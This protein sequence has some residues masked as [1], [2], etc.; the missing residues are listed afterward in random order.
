MQQNE[1]RVDR[2][3]LAY[4]LC[5]LAFSPAAP[6]LARENDNAI[7]PSPSHPARILAPAVTLTVTNTNNSGA[8]SLRAALAT[9]PTGNV[10]QFSLPV[11]SVISVTGGELLAFYQ[12]TIDGST[13]TNLIIDANNAS[14]AINAL[15][16]ITI[17][18]L[19]IQNANAGS[20]GGAG[21]NAQGSLVLTNVSVFSSTAGY[22]GGGVFAQG[23]ATVSG[24]VFRNNRS[25]DEAGGGGGM[26]AISTLE[27]TGTQFISNTAYDQGGGLLAYQN[28]VL[29]NVVFM[30]NSVANASGSGDGGGG[31]LLYGGT[32]AVVNGGMFQ[33]N[34]SNVFGG[35]LYALVRLALSGTQ[36]VNNSAGVA[37]GGV[38]ASQPSTLIGAQFLRNSAVDD[39]GGLA[40]G[41]IELLSVGFSQNTA[42]NGGG[43]SS[44]GTAT[45]TNSVFISNTAL[46]RGGGADL[47][48]VGISSAVSGG[49]F[50]HNTASNGGGVYVAAAITV[51]GTQ[52]VSNT[53]GSRGGGVYLGGP[54]S[55]NSAQF[56]SNSAASHGGGVFAAQ[57][58]TVTDSLFRFNRSV[59]NRGGGA[60]AGSGLILERSRFV[61]NEAATGGG[62]YFADLLLAARNSLFA[63]NLATSG[64]GAGLYYSSTY[65]SSIQHST[66]ASPTLAVGSAI[67]GAAGAL[68]VAN[69]LIASHT[70][71]IRRAGLSI[72]V[73][74]SDNFFAGNTANL[75]GT[76]GSAGQ[77][78]TGNPA[79]VSPAG[80]N[81]HLGA[82]SA[83]INA[84]PF[85]GV[86]SDIDL[87]P[88]VVGC[89]DAGYDEVIK[90]A[91]LCKPAPI[92]NSPTFLG[93]PTTFTATVTGTL[94]VTL[95]W[96]FG[97]GT[98]TATGGVV[99]HT[100]G[101]MGTYTAVVTATNA[102][103]SRAAATLVLVCGT[104][105]SNTNDSGAGS[106]RTAVQ[107]ANAGG[108]ITF[109]P[110]LAGKTI[111]LTSGEI[112][113][114][115]TLTLNGGGAPGVR[116]SAN[117]AS[118]MFNAFSPTTFL[119]LTIQHGAAAGNGGGILS[120][121]A[122]TLTNV[123]VLINTA[124]GSGGGLYTNGDL[125]LANVT[126]VSNTSSGG[127]GGL[128]GDGARNALNGVV[129]RENRCTGADCRGGA[130][131]FL[132]GATLV[133]VQVLTN[134][135]TGGG[136]GVY[137]IGAAMITG[138]VFLNN[139]CTTGACVGGGL[140]QPI[141]L[142]LSISGTQF[143]SNSAGAGGGGAYGGGMVTL[144]GSLF[145][146]NRTSSGFGG[147]LDASGALIMTATQF[148]SNT[149]GAGG[150]A[151][152]SGAAVLEGGVFQGNAA[153]ISGGGFYGI[154]TL[155]MSGTQFIGNQA[156][157]DAGGARAGAAGT[158]RGSLFR[159]NTGTTW[160]GG[161]LATELTLIDTTFLSNTSGYGG[162]AMS[163]LVVPSEVTGGL[164]QGNVA[165]SNDGGGL[166]VN[167]A[168]TIS[169]TQF[170]GNL[171]AGKGGHVNAGL[172]A[173][174][175]TNARFERGVATN[176]GGLY[177]GAGA[178]T[179]TDT[180]VLGNVATGT[181]GAGGVHVVNTATVVGGLFQD[182]RTNGVGGGL[183]A[184]KGVALTGTQFISNSSASNGGGLSLLSGVGRVV[185][186][187]F[188]RNTSPA[189]GG[190]MEFGSPTTVTIV[191]V[192]VVGPQDGVGMGIVTG[193][194][195]AGITNTVIASYTYGIF[196]HTSA[197][198]ENY[199]L[200]H[201]N[202]TE[203]GGA[204][205]SGGNSLIGD[206]RFTN[207]AVDDYHLT[208]GSAARNAG[209][210]AGI[211]VDFEGDARPIGASFDIGYDE[212]R[213]RLF[214]PNTIRN[215]S[216]GW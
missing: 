183:F 207:A 141:G 56:V 149:A 187:L 31:A 153:G 3:I 53:T 110:L 112:V 50:R 52:F 77:T 111:T 71:G 60:Y 174:S 17:A 11:N 83:A 197:V 102:F 1:F 8:G 49:L 163:M 103:G 180:R 12:V 127:G 133:N 195:T 192:T 214:V 176:G 46:G 148:I 101:A 7:A 75:S 196:N 171:A 138:G 208:G 88:R 134:T 118:R 131:R 177:V 96:N 113:I 146:R 147:G 23:P 64:L 14:R 55:L 106:L 40:A 114:S 26:Y 170:I 194:G 159:D 54:A 65:L 68:N 216:S 69:S 126:M 156:A 97:D 24:G 82:G 32:L 178:L 145:Q 201:A 144:A 70:V 160:G 215:R 151:S 67:E 164:F 36:F 81:Y 66:F 27:M 193:M 80:D 172:R 62:V 78:S 9:A 30:S 95:T 212:W 204:V 61:A 124:T 165:R 158:A 105:V 19:T 191:H 100:Y 140:W 18:S 136:G 37:G 43:L 57:P 139:A 135:S 108:T 13:A 152:T 143:I 22:R 51:T 72:F 63:R 34:A 119:S 6:A 21:I 93:N 10:I 129:L 137:V 41:T 25:T 199:N 44:V 42:G 79:F 198:F 200:F 92:N 182:N 185:N 38:F 4:C 125:A 5:S 205:T 94:P 87:H 169:G 206:P 47:F 91:S 33:S 115:K 123:N 213:G 86:S 28:V 15:Q 175:V 104:L 167:G 20:L 85:I 186:S 2:L 59:G 39:G 117:G 188:A 90:A 184:G 210:N 48:G 190:A 157:G 179:M 173:A 89:V 168:L 122:V 45:L 209:V 58:V 130:V 132:G 161:L 202:G 128:Y 189:G 29:T 98:P 116:V 73:T 166:H 150:G 211:V 203:I 181:L 154:G 155:A 162:G 142:P 107:C 76:I 99:A 120:N 121:S 84:S 74:E 16:A 109:D 35:G